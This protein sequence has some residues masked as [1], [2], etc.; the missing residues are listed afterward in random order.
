M[1]LFS[2]IL[3]FNVKMFSLLY[4]DLYFGTIFEFTDK[5]IFISNKFCTSFSCLTSWYFLT[6]LYPINLSITTLW[7]LIKLHRFLLYSINRPNFMVWLPLLLENLG[8]ICITIVCCPVCDVTNLK[9]NHSFLSFLFWK[10]RVRFLVI[11]YQGGYWKNFLW[12]LVRQNYVPSTEKEVFFKKI[13]D[14]RRISFSKASKYSFLDYP[15]SSSLRFF[16]AVLS[17]LKTMKFS[18]SENV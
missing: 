15:F 16:D 11:S 7:S 14:R 10:V 1:L 5:P 17:V 6:F 18:R 9:I 4:K 12:K 2:L 8:N 3:L 13:Y